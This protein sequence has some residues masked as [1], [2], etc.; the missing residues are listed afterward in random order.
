[1][2]TELWVYIVLMHSIAQGPGM[3][4]SREWMATVGPFQTEAACAERRKEQAETDSYSQCM[5]L[6]HAEA[7][8]RPY[9]QGALVLEYR[10]DGCS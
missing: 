6:I 7:L 5:P 3:D 8:T 4:F 2:G 10:K 1:M 9:N